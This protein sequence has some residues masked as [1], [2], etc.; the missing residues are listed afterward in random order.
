M[1]KHRKKSK[2]FAATFKYD[3]L[4][5]SKGASTGVSLSRV[6]FIHAD[7]KTK[8]IKTLKLHYGDPR[9]KVIKVRRLSTETI[10]MLTLITDNLRLPSQHQPL[11]DEYYNNDILKYIYN[12]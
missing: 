7:N 3:N 2:L 5:D 10:M 8:C 6:I 11:S 12:D 9:L 4:F 1:N